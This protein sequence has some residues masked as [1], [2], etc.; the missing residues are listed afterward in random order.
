[1]NDAS[2]KIFTAVL[3]ILTLECSAQLSQS[4]EIGRYLVSFI[5]LRI[6]ILNP[7]GPGDSVELVLNLWYP[8][9][10]KSEAEIRLL[11][12]AH[13]HLST[14]PETEYQTAIEREKQDV[15][16]FIS[17]NFGTFSETDWK[18]V[19]Q[20]DRKS[21]VEGKYFSSKFPLILRTLR[22]F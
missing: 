5:F 21:V 7:N 19:E 8:A 12:Y 22:A 4:L 6:S 15:R 3:F 17:K 10:K 14:L 9:E 13:L 1:M 20:Q 11:D 16:F 18:R 2:L